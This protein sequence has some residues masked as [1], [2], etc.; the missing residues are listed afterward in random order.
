MSVAT[1]KQERAQDIVVLLKQMYPK[2]KCSLDFTNAFEL[3]IATMLSAQSTDVRVNIVTKSLFRKYPN[4]KA[5]AEAGQV[6]MERDVKQT[7]FFRN[8]AKA[9]IAA[10]KMIVDRHGG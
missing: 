3:L 8:K 2:A 6:E 7:G 4:P 5:F 1:K 9:V 10:S